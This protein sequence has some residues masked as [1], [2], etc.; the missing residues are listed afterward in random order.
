MNTWAER[1]EECSQMGR[2]VLTRVETRQADGGLT[3][4]LGKVPSDASHMAGIVH[5]T[6]A[7]S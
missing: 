4:P 2:I 5:G 1:E 6:P 7:R 3:L